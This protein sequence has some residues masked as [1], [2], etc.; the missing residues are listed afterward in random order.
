MKNAPLFIVAP[1]LAKI[2]IDEHHFFLASNTLPH[3]QSNERGITSSRL[4]RHFAFT[5][6]DSSIVPHQ[7]WTED[8]NPAILE[9][10][11]VDERTTY[12]TSDF[13]DQINQSV[14]LRGTEEA[15]KFLLNHVL[16]GYKKVAAPSKSF[17]CALY[18]LEISIRPIYQLYDKDPPSFDRLYHGIYR[19]SIYQELA[20]QHFY[21]FYDTPLPSHIPLHHRAHIDYIA[22]EMGEDKAEDLKQYFH[23]E[24][25][26]SVAMNSI[27]NVLS[28]E[29]GLRIALGIMTRVGPLSNSNHAPGDV[30]ECY[31]LDHG[32]ECHG[33][34]WVI[35]D[36]AEDF[37]ENAINHWSGIAP[38]EDDP[39]RNPVSD[40]DVKDHDSGSVPGNAP[41][42]VIPDSQVKAAPPA[43]SSSAPKGSCITGTQANGSRFSKRSSDICSSTSAPRPAYASILESIGNNPY[44]TSFRLGQPKDYI[45]PS[46]LIP[47]AETTATRPSD[48]PNLPGKRKHFQSDDTAGNENINLHKHHKAIPL[49]RRKP[50]F[51]RNSPPDIMELGFNEDRLDFNFKPHIQLPPVGPLRPLFNDLKG[52]IPAGHYALMPY[53]RFDTP[54]THEEISQ[55]TEKALQL[56]KKRVCNAP[57]W[58]RDLPWDEMGDISPEEL[59]MYFPNHVLRWPFLAVYVLKAHWDDQFQRISAL[60]NRVRGSQCSQRKNRHAEPLPCKTK[61]EAAIKEA[62]FNLG[63]LDEIYRTPMEKILEKVRQ[64]PNKLFGRTLQPVSIKEAAEYVLYPQF[65]VK[66]FCGRLLDAGLLHQ[67]E[68][69][70]SF[71]R[72]EKAMLNVDGFGKPLTQVAVGSGEDRRSSNVSMISLSSTSDVNEGD[73]NWETGRARESFGGDPQR[74]L[75]NGKADRNTRKECH[76]GA[77]CRKENCKFLH[78]TGKDRKGKEP[79]MLCALGAK[80]QHVYCEWEHPVGW[81]PDANRANATPPKFAPNKKCRNGGDF[82][83]PKCEFEHPLGWNPQNNR[84]QVPAPKFADATPCR[85]GSNCRDPTNCTFSHGDKQSQGK[86]GGSQNAKN[87]GQ[88][89]R[90]PK[91][92]QGS[93]DQ[94]KKQQQQKLC[95]FDSKCRTGDCKLAHHGPA[96]DPKIQILLDQTCNYGRRCTNNKCNRCHPSPASKIGTGG[97]TKGGN[98]NGQ[99]NKAGQGSNK[100]RGNDKSQGN[101]GQDGNS[102]RSNGN[103]SQGNN[104]GQG[105]NGQ[106]NNGRGNNGG[107]GGGNNGNSNLASKDPKANPSKPGP[108]PDEML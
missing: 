74:G 100:G 47:C 3:F 2:Y 69:P 9:V 13:V 77:T 23:R 31:V 98:N 41:N 29:D 39:R 18:A 93:N 19:G 87:G 10:F 81:D 95:K 86:N 7:W 61:F 58:D 66:P 4:T 84:N 42:A 94:G 5:M 43:S 101:N 96:A 85:F 50:L 63:N 102:G 90:D 56:S 54:L 57:H 30:Y 40:G 26:S 33:I 89:N 12:E 27:L 55:E 48:K 105:R 71:F 25:L 76:D 97:L 17:L 53:E 92:P 106:G 8:I 46:A 38:T 70:E 108:A 107:K 35:N 51:R 16:S 44:L 78:S 34:A 22:G 21:D 14:Y 82:Q 59:V 88:D 28:I 32:D 79:S 60:I 80:C 49:K 52:H 65:L 6:T 11:V 99:G 72:R 83:F 73:T 75:N 104:N 36:M 68:H 24:K 15:A 37:N 45:T 20:L 67:H 91:Q 1:P 103:N 64:P 62:G